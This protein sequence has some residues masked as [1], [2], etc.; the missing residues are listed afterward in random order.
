M[1]IAKHETTRM[2]KWPMT[3]QRD[4][5]V[6]T[7]S[8]P[9]A[10]YSDACHWKRWVSPGAR[11]HPRRSRR[12]AHRAAGMGR[13]DRPVG[14]LHRRLRRQ[15]IPTHRPR[16]HVGLQTPGTLG[17]RRGDAAA[18][19][20]DFRSWDNADEESGGGYYY[21]PGEIE[22]LWVLDIDGT[23]VVISTGAV[24]R[25]H[26]RRLTLISPPTCSTRSASSRP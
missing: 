20:P 12:R 9:V 23:V 14:H 19:Y 2:T 18:M 16:R 24:A 17:T 5:G 3:L 7:F 26:R 8:H 11:G 13:G 1:D 22:T 25:S 15:S 4:I 6:M 10:V 21:E